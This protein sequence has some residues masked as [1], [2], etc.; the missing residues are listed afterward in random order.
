MKKLTLVFAI[1]L[2]TINANAQIKKGAVL[3]GGQVTANIGKSTTVNT[4]QNYSESNSS[5]SIGLSFG[6]AVSENNVLGFNIYTSF[7]KSDGGI[8]GN[9][10]SERYN[11]VG[12]GIFYRKY[13]LL[14]KDFYFFG[15]PN[16]GFNFGKQTRNNNNPLNEYSTSSTNA[17][18]ALGTGLSYKVY[19]KLQLEV[20][21]PTLIGIQY[22][23]SKNSEAN[24]PNINQTSNQFSLN[25]GINS[26]LLNNLTLG[27]RLFL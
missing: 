17:Y 4:S 3:L 8:S 14:A 19:K 16:I 10:H 23:Y 20:A 5:T 22:S 25:T 24:Q 7:S 2:F 21:L 11:A 12:I 26:Q 1:G 27:F 6:K 15:E 13:K 9:I 18:L